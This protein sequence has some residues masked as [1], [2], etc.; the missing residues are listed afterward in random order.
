MR[1]AELF[2]MGVGSLICAS[3][4]Y[5]F[6]SHWPTSIPTPPPQMTAQKVV[7]AQGTFDTE[8]ARFRAAFPCPSDKITPAEEGLGRLYGCIIGKAETG[9]Y[10]VNE[11]PD[12]NNR[13][14]NI[15]VM[16]NDW[17]K[18]IGY[19]THADKSEAEGL[20]KTAARLYAP[21]KEP[22]LLAMFRSKEDQ[23][24]EADGHSFAYTYRRG[25]KIDERLIT[26][27]RWPPGASD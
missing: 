24:L 14:E 6:A 25:P 26:I 27:G 22:Q 18:D 9:K 8:V 19:G 20:V 15:K 3:V 10:F 1:N 21:S 16:W 17:F 12:S 23:T 5:G 13:V 7:P 4:L 11:M 2:V